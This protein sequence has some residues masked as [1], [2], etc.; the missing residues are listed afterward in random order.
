[1]SPEKLESDT[2]NKD[3]NDIRSYFENIRE[4]QRSP[5]ITFTGL[6]DTNTT[7]GIRKHSS[8]G[9]STI[10]MAKFGRES[11]AIFEEMVSEIQEMGNFFFEYVNGTSIKRSYRY[12]SDVILYD[13]DEQL[14]KCVEILR[15]Y[16]KIRRNGM[17]GFSVEDD[18][19]H[20][21]HDCSFASGSC[22]DGFRQQIKSVAKFTPVRTEN[23]SIFQFTPTDWYDVFI[24]FFLRKRG[25]REIWIGGKSWK[26]PTNDQLV[27]WTEKY[28]AGVEMVRSKDI[29]TDSISERRQVDQEDR[30]SDSSSSKNVYGK[31]ARITNKYAY[32]KTE[33]KNLLQKFYISPISAIRDMPDFRNNYILSDP[34]NKDYIQAAFDDFG[35]DLN[36]YSLRDFYILLK[37]PECKP[38]FINS[39]NYGNIE[40]STDIINE[41]LLFQFDN[42]ESEICRFL[43]TLV[44]IFD[45]KISKKNTICVLSPPSAGKNFFFDMIL[46]ISLNYGQLGQ[47]N[48]HNVFAFQEAPNKRILLWNEPNY[49][50]ALHDTIKMMLGGDPFT[51]RVKHNMDTH[52]RR[53]PVIILTN[54]PVSFMGDS[55]FYDRVAYFNWNYASF[56]KDVQFKPYPMC[57]F[58]ILNKYNIN[59]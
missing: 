56:L 31:R 40:E 16:G 9:E 45:K 24:Y 26:E 49:E 29:G 51:V 28:N 5:T 47:A 21:I 48:R 27:R 14:H 23:K 30:E 55:A 32:I 11:P 43:N 4:P 18:H 53:T 10:S 57:F 37:N 50:S 19:I 12:L 59:F 35:R 38:I 52:V 6:V 46:A 7:T 33:T 17:F 13:T 44:D 39:M 3:G 36:D 2:K 34:K 25:T 42:D 1:M 41:L 54:T 22:R 20:V 58:E 8:R 15:E